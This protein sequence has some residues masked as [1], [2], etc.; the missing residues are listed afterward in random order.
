M[1]RDLEALEPETR[2]MAE[3]LLRAARGAFAA[4]RRD[5]ALELIVTGTLRTW[6]EQDALYEQGRF[7]AGPIVTNAR[8]GKSW[9]NFGR[10]FDVAFRCGGKVSWDGPWEEL[11]ELGESIGLEWGGRFSSPDRPHFQHRSGLTLAQAREA[12]NR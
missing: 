6:E 9:H 10:A 11:G 7:R 3:M 8:G 5:E 12:H 2:R 4:Y 1:R